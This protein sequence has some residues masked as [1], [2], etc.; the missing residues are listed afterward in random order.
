M[1]V[2][3]GAG[4]TGLSIAREI[5]RNGIIDITIIEKEQ[6]LGKHASGRN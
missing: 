4:I 1:I 3:C 6:T 2:I 5:V